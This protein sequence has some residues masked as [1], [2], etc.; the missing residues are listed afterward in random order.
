MSKQN[1]EKQVQQ[2]MEEF[3]L[4]PSPPVWDKI[5]EQIKLKRVKRR[6]FW[7]LPAL[8]L[9][10]AIG[11]W[12]LSSDDGNDSK[13]STAGNRQTQVITPEN[14][15]K[16]IVDTD[17]P[18]IKTEQNKSYKEKPLQQPFD[19]PTTSSRSNSIAIHP[20]QV[21]SSNKGKTVVTSTQLDRSNAIATARVSKTNA[22]KT[23]QA[24]TDQSKK[25]ES[26]IAIADPTLIHPTSDVS[27]SDTILFSKK[28]STIVSAD[29]PSVNQSKSE[30][31]VTPTSEKR[32]DITKSTKTKATKKWEK[33][34][35]IQAGWSEY[36]EGFFTNSTV[37]RNF[38]SPTSSPVV[39]SH[40]PNQP[41]KGPSFAIGAGFKIKF[42][43][44]FSLN[45][46][47][48]YHYY[49]TQM[50]VGEY[51]QRGLRV[52]YGTNT[53]RILNFYAPG[54]R[55]DYTNQFH[56][57]EVPLSVIYNPI[58]KIPLTVSAGAAYGRLFNSNALT[59][60]RRT[61]VHYYNE[62]NNVKDHISVFSAF[63]YQFRSKS[64]LRLRAGPIIQYNPSLIQKENSYTVPHLFFAGLKTD[65]SF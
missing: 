9:V 24:D 57:L 3:N 62:E 31:E 56:V 43:E 12:Y 23:H 63:Q 46:L 54:A 4:V 45:G 51:I 27:E 18:E 42:S 17:K 59:H 44:K 38:A 26:D 32:S 8:L 34:V 25:I 41:T 35:S 22:D 48:Q 40:F 39:G 16:T 28:E 64:N 20:S 10:T 65:L 19:V 21:A 7:A 13:P 33:V 29:E 11:W 49:S 53:L 2:K 1:F 47:V 50:K 36:K 60:D 58:N 37:D 5:E 61:N 55:H 15:N 30:T 6:L 14:P 52:T